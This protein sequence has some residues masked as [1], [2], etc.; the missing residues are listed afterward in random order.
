MKLFICLVMLL[1]MSCTSTVRGP[2]SAA[3]APDEPASCEELHCEFV[4]MAMYCQNPNT[5]WRES[6]RQYACLFRDEYLARCPN[7]QT[8]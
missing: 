1:M 4:E 7:A 3:H 6:Q 8:P 2:V 5:R